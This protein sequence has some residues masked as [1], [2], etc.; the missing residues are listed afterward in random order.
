MLEIDGRTILTT[1]GEKISPDHTA[2]VVIDCQREFIEE[3]RFWDRTTGP[4]GDEVHSGQVGDRSTLATLVPRLIAFLDNARGAGIRIVHVRAIYDPQ[5]LTDPMYERLYRLGV[6][7]YCQSDDPSSEY[8]PG[9]EPRPGEPEV[10]KHRFDAFYDTDLDIILR[11]WG[12]RTIIPTGLVTH[13]C[14]DS[15]ARHGYFK[16]YYLVFPEDLTGGAN[17]QVHKVTLDVMR[18]GF[19]VTASAQEMLGIWAGAPLQAAR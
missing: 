14:V 5:Y 11:S 18:H 7:H 19:G 12:I 8:Y 16:G 6:G 3:G 10:I 9:L 13:G 15:T 1:L 4:N 17:E 2:V